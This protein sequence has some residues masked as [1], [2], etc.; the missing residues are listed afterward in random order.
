MTILVVHK[1]TVKHTKM[2]IRQII[3]GNVMTDDDAFQK[4]SKLEVALK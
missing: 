4:K 2:K 1:M 3:N